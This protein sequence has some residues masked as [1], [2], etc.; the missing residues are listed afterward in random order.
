M[1]K[2]KRKIESM[3]KPN[4]KQKR[5]KY[6]E[7]FDNIPL[8]PEELAKLVLSTPPARKRG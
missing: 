5:S 3:S 1:S 4:D 7:Y 2:E 6:S 8:K